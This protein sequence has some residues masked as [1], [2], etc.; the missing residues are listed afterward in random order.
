M[1]SVIQTSTMIL[2]TS[3][4]VPLSG[5][6]SEV[7]AWSDVLCEVEQASID[8]N[9]EYECQRSNTDMSTI[10]KSGRDTVLEAI[11]CQHQ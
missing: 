10:S 8:C 1:H 6:L 2:T 4:M 11:C 7:V 5:N 9:L 3:T